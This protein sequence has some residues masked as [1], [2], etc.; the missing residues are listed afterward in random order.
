MTGLH[1]QPT[2]IRGVKRMP[3][4]LVASRKA[5]FL[6]TIR[7]DPPQLHDPLRVRGKGHPPAVGR[8]RGVILV[9]WRLC[10]PLLLTRRH[11]E[12]EQLTE[13]T[14]EMRVYEAA[15]IRRERTCNVPAERRR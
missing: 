1:V 11:V 3:H 12:H 7:G 4:A 14:V 9:R 15:A 13:G 2:A 8:P 5:L 6:S 10:E